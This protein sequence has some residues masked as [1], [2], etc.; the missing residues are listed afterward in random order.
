MLP[1]LA[2]ASRE[3]EWAD[4]RRPTWRHGCFHGDERRFNREVLAE[5]VAEMRAITNDDLERA[6]RTL[7]AELA[8]VR[9][10]FATDRTQALDL[11]PLPKRPSALQWR[12]RMMTR[13]Q[14]KVGIQIA[15]RVAALRRLAERTAR[16]YEA[17]VAADNSLPAEHRRLRRMLFAIA[18]R[19]GRK[20][21]R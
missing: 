1:W 2:W 14:I 11:P 5:V 10:A 7:T 20:G 4:E 15:A 13:E 8:E 21:A 16:D 6:V 12:D 9:L 17:D 19:R 18:A 3:T